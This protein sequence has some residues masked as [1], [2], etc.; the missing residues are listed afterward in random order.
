LTKKETGDLHL[1]KP[2]TSALRK[3]YAGR[4]QVLGKAAGS[5]KEERG[6]TREDAEQTRRGAASPR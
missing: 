4:Q 5:K 3:E 2:R 6:L 1:G